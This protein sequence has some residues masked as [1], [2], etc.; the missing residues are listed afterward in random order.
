MQLSATF[1]SLRVFNVLACA[2]T[3]SALIKILGDFFKKISRIFSFCAA[4][5]YG[6]FNLNDAHLKLHERLKKLTGDKNEKS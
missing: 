1:E 3:L 2:L 4:W 6:T 5:V